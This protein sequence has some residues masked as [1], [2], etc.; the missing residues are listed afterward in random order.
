MH[1]ACVPGFEESN[2]YPGTLLEHHHVRYVL[3]GHWEDFFRPRTAPLVPLYGVLDQGSL[4]K[5]VEIVEHE[6]PH[7]RGVAPLNKSDAECTAPR[8]CGPRGNAWALP[9]PGET[10]QF[11]TGSRKP[12][13]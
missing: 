3:M 4:N 11:A 8:L 5:F 13:P 9:I 7:A 1:I 6:L 12:R 2:D 10:Y